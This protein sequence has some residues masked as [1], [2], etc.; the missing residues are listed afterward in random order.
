MQ[1]QHT[2]QMQ[3]LQLQVEQLAKEVDRRDRDIQTLDGHIRVIIEE[4]DAVKMKEKE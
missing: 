2:M 1:S 3:N 4:N